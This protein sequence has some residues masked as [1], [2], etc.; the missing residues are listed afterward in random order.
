MV[1]DVFSLSRGGS[2]ET[3]RSYP[4]VCGAWFHTLRSLDR[5]CSFGFFAA[6]WSLHHRG[7]LLYNYGEYF[8]CDLVLLEFLFWSISLLRSLV[9][10]FRPLGVS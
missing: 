3:L 4:W 10:S 8:L 1:V 9:S 6:G 2:A 5:A 7:F